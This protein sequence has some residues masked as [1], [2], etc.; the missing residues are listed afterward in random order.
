MKKRR[1]ILYLPITYVFI[2]NG[3]I[4]YD[5]FEFLQKDKF[6]FLL[7]ITFPFALYLTCDLYDDYRKFRS[8]G[9]PVNVKDYCFGF[10]LI[11][12]EFLLIMVVL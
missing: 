9:T 2:C 5:I 12:V 11:G 4:I 6:S 3:L 1:K 10:F 8:E 7:W